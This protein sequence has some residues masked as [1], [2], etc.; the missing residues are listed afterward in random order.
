MAASVP[1]FPQASAPVPQGQPVEGMSRD[2]L[3]RVMAEAKALTDSDPAGMEAL[4]ERFPALA[5]ALVRGLNKLGLASKA[6]TTVMSASQPA[7]STAAAPAPPA[8]GHSSSSRFGGA[9]A[10]AA[11]A[12]AVVP[13]SV[14]AKKPLLQAAPKPATH[15]AGP[16]SLL[17]GP[18]S[19]SSSSSSSASSAHQFSRYP[20]QP[21]HHSASSYHPAPAGAADPSHASSYHA[22]HGAPADPRMAAQVDPRFAAQAPAPAE[23][24]GGDRAMIQQILAMTDAE[25]MAL[26]PAERAQVQNVRDAL[27]L[28]MAVIQARP[29]AERDLLLRT[30]AELQSVV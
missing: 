27:M 30:R 13:A 18:S 9:P 7:T 8:A 20:Q 21:P 1:R 28:P 12:S 23:S 16:S 4:L 25:V 22:P 2:E 15:S 3:W 14:R 5:G 26:P 17:S 24:D 19:S 6:L 11:A 29:A 10:H